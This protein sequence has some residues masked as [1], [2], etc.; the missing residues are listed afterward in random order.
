MYINVK[1]DERFYRRV[2]KEL[3]KVQGRCYA[4]AITSKQILDYCNNVLDEIYLSV[5]TKK[6]LT[7]TIAS[8]DINAQ[9]FPNVYKYA[10]YSTIFTVRYQKNHWSLIDLKR[11]YTKSSE[12]EIEVTLS[13]EAKI[14]I[15]SYYEKRKS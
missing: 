14:C 1:D 4:R 11:D 5:C 8:V 7:G 12:S 9:N 15:I 3:K 6:A 13:D 2:D 10:A